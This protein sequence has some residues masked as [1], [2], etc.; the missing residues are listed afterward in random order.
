M[1]AEALE[2]HLQLEKMQTE[3]RPQYSNLMNHAAHLPELYLRLGLPQ[4]AL[5]CMHR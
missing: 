2:Q 5:E 1:L 4:K 3:Y